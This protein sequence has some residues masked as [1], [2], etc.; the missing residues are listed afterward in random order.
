MQTKILSKLILKIRKYKINLKIIIIKIKL[1]IKYNKNTYEI[2]MDKKGENIATLIRNSDLSRYFPFRILA[3][4]H[5]QNS[6]YDIIPINLKRHKRNVVEYDSVSNSHALFKRTNTN[7]K[8]KKK[9]P[10]LKKKTYH[11]VKNNKAIPLMINKQA[12]EFDHKPVELFIEYMIVTDT[13]LFN[14]HIRYSQTNN[15]N[16]LFLFMKAYFA[17][18]V[19]G[20]NQ[21]F[22]NSF[23]NDQDLRITVK[24]SNYL[25]LKV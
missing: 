16:L 20:I 8:I 7:N 3:T 19:N 15:T 25:F 4:I 13:S 17:H 2:Y 9:N 1:F 18:Y 21:I 14:D 24:L 22:V 11:S 6:T 10:K 12:H 23:Q 5:D